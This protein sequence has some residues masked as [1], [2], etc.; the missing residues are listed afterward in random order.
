MLLEIE[1]EGARQVRQN[2]PEALQIFL[3]PPSVEEL[4]HRI[5]GRGTESEASIQ[6]R[7]ER[8]RTE[9]AAQGEFDAVVVNDDLETALSELER[10]MRLTNA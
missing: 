2:F 5:R 9:L 3:A 8:A 6:R 10:L 1:L 4:E 7:L